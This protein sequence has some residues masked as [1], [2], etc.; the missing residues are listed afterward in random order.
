MVEYFSAIA[1]QKLNSYNFQMKREF[2]KLRV[3]ANKFLGR[4][5]QVYVEDKL[6]LEFHGSEYGGWAIPCNFVNSSST[7]IDVGLGEDIS[8]SQSLIEQYSCQVHGFDPTP[9]AIEFVNN[10]N[11]TD[12]K[13][14]PVGLAAKSGKA[15]FH[16]PNNQGHVSGTVGSAKHTG[17]SKLEVSLVSLD[18]ALLL[19]NAPHVDLLKIDIEGAEYEVLMSESFAKQAAKISIICLEFHHRWESIGKKAT[20]TAV[21][22]LRE[23]GFVCCWANS[24]TNEE[25][26]FCNRK[27]LAKLGS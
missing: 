27:N 26:T 18:D 10:L 9:R 7:V 24:Q 19:I 21:S 22:R 15:Q 2:R 1:H 16:L 14:H 4:E 17:I 12:F 5:P 13:L 8:F 25:F 23:L 11:Q 3:I 6:A 20:L